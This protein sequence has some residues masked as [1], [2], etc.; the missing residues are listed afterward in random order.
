MARKIAF[1]Y[2]RAVDEAT[3]LFWANGYAGTGLRDLLKAMGIG[4]GSFY[5]TV[6][7]KKNLYL[8][9]LDRYT[10]TVIAGRMRALDEPETGA[11][12]VRAFFRAILDRLDNPDTPS[13]LC[14]LAAMED[15]AVIADPELRTRAAEVIA[16]L[17]KALEDRLD[18]Y[19][20]PLNPT[21]VAAVLTTYIQGLWHVA[22]VS[23]DRKQLER[24]IESVL[25]GLG[26]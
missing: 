12:G 26:V 19:A 23:Y 24:E 8:A 11:E 7:S 16:A 9:C 14:M 1:D 20:G 21:A 22:L 4:E 3:T 25:T 5:N 13:R 15:E 18:D 2:D 6:G 17:R 10:A